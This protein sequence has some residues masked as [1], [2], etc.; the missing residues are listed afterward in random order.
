VSHQS[1]TTY[2]IRNTSQLE[3]MFFWA[4]S[5][6]FDMYKARIAK[7]NIEW[8][9]EIP[10]GKY[11]SLFLLQWANSTEPINNLYVY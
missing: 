7:S 10:P 4:Q 3:P 1:H 9:I 5:Y 8:V 2:L 6:G 11:Q